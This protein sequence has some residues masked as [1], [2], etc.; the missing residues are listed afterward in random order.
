MMR[1]L[2]AGL[3]SMLILAAGLVLCLLFAS[4]DWVREALIGSVAITCETGAS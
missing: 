1:D 3:S 2:L 4:Y